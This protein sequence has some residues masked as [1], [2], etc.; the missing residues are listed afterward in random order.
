MVLPPA[1]RDIYADQH[2][3]VVIQKAAQVGISEYLINCVLW[4]ADTGQGGRGNA[5]YIMPTQGQVDDFSQARVD[6]AIGESPHLQQR[7]FPAPPGRPGP[8]RQRLKKVGDGYL[9]L[10]GAD[11]RRQLSSVD[12]DVVVLDEF[13]LM[14]EGVLE[15]AEKRLGSSRLGWLRVASTPRLPEAGINNRFLHS[16]RHYYFLKCPGCGTAQRLEWD[17]NVDKKRG[18]LVCRRRSCRKPL[19]LLAT[20]RWEPEAPGNERI[21]GYHMSRLYSPF[22]DIPKLIEESE[23]TT[24]AAVQEFRSAVLGETY[25]PAGGRLTV[26][27]L[28]KCRRDYELPEGS[29]E[30]TCMGVD[31]GTVLHVVIRQPLKGA[32]GHSRALYIREVGGFDDLSALVTRYNVQCAIVDGLPE[33]R[34]S[35]E[36]AERHD[37][38]TAGV[39]YYDRAEPGYRREKK[40][41]VFYYHINRTYCLEEM[42]AS[43]LAGDT[44]LPQSAR[45]LGG[46]VKDGLGEYYREMLALNRVR[47]QNAQGNW[48]D[49]FV[50]GGKADHYAHAE[51]YCSIAVR[52]GQDFLLN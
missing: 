26:D 43:V 4:T 23:V 35:K 51:T 9:Y 47:E 20:G 21:R 6:R 38:I 25:V 44:E 46:R 18:L 28:D 37:D 3:F 29:K 8:V 2:P 41:G 5:L 11:S 24:P 33:E 10:R 45:H 1:L 40:R 27:V 13:D 50:D 15:L 7:L 17:E 32:P 34:L 19:D 39:A 49:K 42:F 52:W 12:A 14:E 31:V 16:D 22:A 48:V 30:A 36:F